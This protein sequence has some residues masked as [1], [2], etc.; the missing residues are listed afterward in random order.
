MEVR[1]IDEVFFCQSRKKAQ[2]YFMYFEHF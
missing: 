2:K 1:G